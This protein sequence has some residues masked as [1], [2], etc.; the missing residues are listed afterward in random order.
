MNET[1]ASVWKLLE[2]YKENVVDGLVSAV[3]LALIALSLFAVYI[4][5][6]RGRVIKLRSVVEEEEVEA[7]KKIYTAEALLTRKQEIQND[8]KNNRGN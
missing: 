3:I 5:F 4:F 1:L 6:Q 8:R 7:Q 2:P